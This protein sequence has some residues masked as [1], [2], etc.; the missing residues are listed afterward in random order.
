MTQ[1]GSDAYMAV[2]RACMRETAIRAAEIK[3][4]KK[5][6]IRRVTDE[7]DILRRLT[8]KLRAELAQFPKEKIAPRVGAARHFSHQQKIAQNALLAV[9]REPSED[10]QAL[11]ALALQSISGDVPPIELAAPD[12]SIIPDIAGLICEFLGAR[13]PQRHLE[14]HKCG[15]CHC[16][17]IDQRN[18]HNRYVNAR[19]IHRTRRQSHYMCFEC[20]DLHYEPDFLGPVMSCSVCVAMCGCKGG[21]CTCRPFE[22]LPY[23]LFQN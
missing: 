3:K 10:T 16:K 14:G 13:K 23:H 22:I 19:L 15:V 5:I 6:E 12:Y 4:L 17:L 21:K 7:L 1:R 18:S 2:A 20:I 11:I 8:K 9:V